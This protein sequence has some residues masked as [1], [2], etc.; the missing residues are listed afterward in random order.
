MKIRPF[1]AVVSLVTALAFLFGGWFLYQWLDVKQPVAELLD[2]E[3]HI[4]RY[5]ITVT[6]AGVTVELDVAPDFSL[7]RDYLVLMERIRDES[8]EQNV[9]LSLLDKPNADLQTTWHDLYFIVA[10]GIA[11]KEYSAMVERLKAQ[12]LEK[13]VDLQVA[14][15]ENFLY[16]W[17]REKHAENESLFRAMPLEQN[18]SEV[19][20]DA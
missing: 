13:D 2:G 7:T 19:Y 16:V 14:M 18:R 10:E 3:K 8:G 17:L 6:P 15:D 1:P 11:N 12:S 20:A 9:T 4:N 5:D